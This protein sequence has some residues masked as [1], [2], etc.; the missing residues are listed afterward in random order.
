[1]TEFKL[2]LGAK[3]G[4]SYQKEIKSPH[5]DELLKKKIGETVSGDSIGFSGYEFLVTGG[6]DKCGFPM[7]KG[8]QAPRKKIL[9][10]GSVGFDGKNR[11]GTKQPG[12]IQRTTVCGEMITK[13]IHQINMK[14]MKEGAEPL[15]AAE[16]KE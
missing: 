3:D 12:L 6:S 13:I 2:V 8:I 5:A 10:G 1:M 4:K 14:V 11:H 15:V 9:I 7:R 16:K